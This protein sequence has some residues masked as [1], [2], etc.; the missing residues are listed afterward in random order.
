M[1]VNYFLTFKIIFYIFQ[2][3]P[4]M[5]CTDCLKVDEKFEHLGPLPVNSLGQYK[6]LGLLLIHS[7]SYFVQLRALLVNSLGLIEKL[8]ALLGNKSS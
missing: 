6:Q 2:I 4:K 5:V 1:I 8:R 3:A 7:F